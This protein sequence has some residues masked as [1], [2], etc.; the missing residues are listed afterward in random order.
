MNLC[1]L[2]WPWHKSQKLCNENL[3]TRHKKPLIMLLVGL[4]L[5]V[6]QVTPKTLEG[7]AAAF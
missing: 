5:R 6:V 3:T 1:H 4:L 7:I 2:G